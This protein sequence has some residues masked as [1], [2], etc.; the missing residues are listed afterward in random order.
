MLIYLGADHR[1]FQIKEYIKVLLKNMGYEVSDMGSFRYDA[2][3]DYPEFASLVAER[4]SRDN[5]NSRGI[6]I[7]GS[8]VGMDI[9][10]NKFPLVRSAL[11]TSSDQAF[12][13]RNDDDANILCLASNYLDA[14]TIKKITLTWLKTPFSREERYRRRINTIHQI[15]E[16]LREIPND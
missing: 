2:N 14:E 1:G 10:A 5:E 13:S 15:E 3:D 12:D 7:C 4:V 11:V 8:G 9:I 6:L 16:K